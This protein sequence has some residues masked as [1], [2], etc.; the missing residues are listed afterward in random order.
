MLKIPQLRFVLL[1]FAAGLRAVVPIM[2]LMLLIIYL[3]A[4]VGRAM[5]GANDRVHFG[6]MG[7]AMLALFQAATL[8]AWGDMYMVN[9]Y[10]CERYD[11]GGAFER[12]N[13]TDVRVIR[14]LCGSFNHWDCVAPTPMPVTAAVYFYTFTLLTAFVVLSLFISVITTAMFEA[15][16]RRARS[17]R[18]A[19]AALLG[20]EA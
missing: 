11:S 4:I 7:V 19:A 10:G 6:D 2:L 3:Y 13:A 14:T 9:A 1:G 15:R 12:R 20:D 8:S 16:E 18:D 5:F 17:V